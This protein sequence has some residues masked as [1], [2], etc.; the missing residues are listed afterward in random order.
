MSLW[1]SV[2]P[3]TGTGGRI[4]D[5]QA[6][7]VGAN[8]MAGTAGYSVGQLHIPGYELPWEDPD[9]KYPCML[10]SVAPSR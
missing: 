7:G 9:Y 2:M 4:R 5:V 10:L 6:T 3:R 8:V 1:R